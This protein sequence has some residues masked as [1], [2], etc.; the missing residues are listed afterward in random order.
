MTNID[1]VRTI[2]RML[3]EARPAAEGPYERL[4]AYVTARPG[5]ARR[6]A[7][8]ARKIERELGWRP[9][10]T[11]ATGFRKTVCWY[12]EHQEW[13]AHVLSGTYKDWIAANYSGR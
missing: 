8:D 2:C 12:L 3:D 5:H 7:I 10:E 13:V 9:A 11:F 4:V 6:Y 1:V